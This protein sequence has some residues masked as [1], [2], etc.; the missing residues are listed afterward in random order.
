MGAVRQPGP[1]VRQYWALRR[2][3]LTEQ[4]AARLLAFI[5]GMPPNPHDWTNG[6]V[7]LYLALKHL[8]AT[9]RLEP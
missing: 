6:Q 2:L 1:L 4:E 7:A 9:G 8:R 5:E 3:G